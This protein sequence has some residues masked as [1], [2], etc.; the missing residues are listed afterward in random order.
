[1]NDAIDTHVQLL[2][3][4]AAMKI[5][6]LI[7]ADYASVDTATGKLN[8]IGAFGR[9]F[10]NQFPGK[11]QRMTVVVKLV[12]DSPTE[13]TEPRKF[14]LVL[15]DEDGLELFQASHSVSIPRDQFGNRSDA[16]V[17][18]ELNNLEFPHPGT[19]EF[20]VRIDGEEIG[21][22]PIELIQ[23]KQ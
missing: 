9:I 11:H 23:F 14:E 10:F 21:N 1:M 12:A 22:T 6:M 3:K 7:V 5:Q 2:R 18:L 13:T 8:V 4:T 15:A 19:Y 16:N 20:S 17:L